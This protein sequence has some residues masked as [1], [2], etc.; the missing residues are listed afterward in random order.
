MIFERRDIL[1]QGKRQESSTGVY[2]VIAKG[3]A[4]ENNFSQIRERKYFLY[5]DLLAKRCSL[6]H[7]VTLRLLKIYTGDL[8]QKFTLDLYSF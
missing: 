5:I 3:I 4:R 8:S 2:H 6:L 7:Q 1:A